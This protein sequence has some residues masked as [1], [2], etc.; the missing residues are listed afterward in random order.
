MERKSVCQLLIN[1]KFGSFQHV[2]LEKQQTY[3]YLLERV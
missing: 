2:S 1:F 3:I